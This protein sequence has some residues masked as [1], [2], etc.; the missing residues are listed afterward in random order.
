VA[1][2]SLGWVALVGPADSA[3]AAT[4]AEEYCYDSLGRLQVALLCGT[5]YRYHYDA[6]GNLIER[7]VAAGTAPLVCD[8]DRDGLPD[9]IETN[10]GDFGSASDTGTDPFLA[11]TDGDG[12]TDGVETNTGT[13]VSPSDTGSNPHD[14]DTDDDGVDDG[15]E[16]H[17]GSD[18]N[19][20][21]A[22]VPALSPL[23]SRLLMGL[24]LLTGAGIAWRTRRARG[25]G[26]LGL[27][28][29]SG[30]TLFATPA[31]AAVDCGPGAL[32]LGATE[33]VKHFQLRATAAEAALGN[34]TYTVSAASGSGCAVSPAF[35][36]TAQFADFSVDACAVP[37]L[38]SGT[39]V[40]AWS[41]PS[42][43]SGSCAVH[44]DIVTDSPPP[45]SANNRDA[46]R[47]G[48]VDLF[49]GERVV[50]PRTLL[51]LGGRL[52]VVFAVNYASAR[53]RDGQGAFG[54][55]DN[56]RHS[57]DFRLFSVGARSEIRIA[58]PSGRTLH[59]G[60]S[61]G[62][63]TLLGPLETPY[64]LVAD[65]AEHV[66]LH[67]WSHRRYRFNAAGQL[68]SI[69]D[70]NGNTLTL[71]YNSQLLSE[72]S[73]G[74]GRT[75]TFGYDA[76][77]FLAQVGDG[78][79]TVSFSVAAR[80]LVQWT[81]AA[82]NTTQFA[83]SNAV[84]DTPGLLTQV[85]DAGGSVAHTFGYSGS[86]R[87]VSRTAASLASGGTGGTVSFALVGSTAT[88]LDEASG[89]WTFTLDAE[90]NPLSLVDAGGHT[91]TWS[92]DAQGRRTS[93]VDAEGRS[94]SVA[95][96]ATHGA[97]SQLNRPDAST[98]TVAFASA[99]DA[100]GL[101]DVDATSWIDFDGTTGSFV[102]DAAGNVTS[103]TDAAGQ[104]W[105]LSYDAAGAPLSATS[106]TGVVATFAYNADGTLV[107][108]TDAAGNVTAWDYDPL[109]RPV[110]TQ[111]ADATGREQVFD[112]NDRLTD[113]TD[114]LGQT[115]QIGRDGLGRPVL[116]IDPALG[117]WET[118]Y[119]IMGAAVAT[120]DPLGAGW[121][122]G[123]DE[124]QLLATVDDPTSV[125]TQ[126]GYD[127]KGSPVL[128]TDNAGQTRSVTVDNV[129]V[130]RSFT[131]RL[132]DTWTFD[133]DLLDRPIRATSPLG[134]S[135]ERTVDL[136]GRTMSA[137]GPGGRTW[138]V[139][140]DA[141]GAVS[142]RTGP[143]GSQASI[144]RNTAGQATTFTD[145]NGASWTQ[146]FDAAG[147]LQSFSDPL[148]NATTQSYDTRNRMNQQSFPGGLGNLVVSYDGNGRLSQRAYSDGTTHSYSHDANGRLSGATGVTLTR[149]AVGRVT[150]SNGIGT[151]YDPAGRITQIEYGPGVWVQYGYDANGWLQSVTDWTDPVSP[152]V[153]IDRNLE[154]L[155]VSIARANGTSTT[156]TYD[157]DGRL[158]SLQHLGPGP[159]SL[160]EVTIA[161]GA[162][163]RPASKS[164]TAAVVELGS[165]V[166]TQTL[167]RNSAGWPTSFDGGAIA[168]NALGRRLS[169]LGHTFTPRL[170]GTLASMTVGA[171]AVAFDHDA[172]GVP[173]QIAAG[174]ESTALTWNYATPV[175]T[176]AAIDQGANVQLN[177]FDPQTGGL[178]YAVDPL[179]DQRTDVHFDE[180]G[181]AVLWTDAAG[182]LLLAQ[183]YSPDG[184]E[185][186]RV[187]DPAASGLVPIGFG[188]GD[189]WLELGALF[190]VP[191]G[192]VVDPKTASALRNIEWQAPYFH[193][194][195]RQ[196]ISNLDS[197]GAAASSE[198][199]PLTFNGEAWVDG[200]GVLSPSSSYG[201]T[202]TGVAQQ[203][204]EIGG[205]IVKLPK[206]VT[207]TDD[208]DVPNISYR[209]PWMGN[210]GRRPP[211]GLTKL[212]GN[213]VEVSIALPSRLHVM[214][215]NVDYGW[216]NC[217]YALPAWLHDTSRAPSGHIVP[218]L[219][220]R[221]A[222]FP[223][224]PEATPPCVSGTSRLFGSSCDAIA[225]P[226]GSNLSVKASAGTPTIRL[227]GSS[228]ASGWG[229]CGGGSDGGFLGDHDQGLLH[230]Q[231]KDW[232]SIRRTGKRFAR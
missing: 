55:G 228:S 9:T 153:A 56:W 73:D 111:Y 170:D 86:G 120:Q 143:D 188:A 80:K 226:A 131:N 110:Q 58:L 232:E 148:G 215:G 150:G 133:Y 195:N 169:G 94:W 197:V 104:T 158:T 66:L 109:R 37:S 208:I 212:L 1:V 97:I 61:G 223:A 122:L 179:T 128:S 103:L 126:I 210:S 70:R 130:P 33:T 136:L 81:D 10:T 191:G 206:S 106:P 72:V 141:R 45:S 32:T 213:A 157:D 2:L 83:Y 38:G 39:V 34:T 29:S 140:R 192:G 189:G 8:A 71:T 205:F 159:V 13:F 193:N 163:G 201:R 225:S 49:T 125:T 184:Q 88:V 134:V 91:R 121:T 77:N 90:G 194:G 115:I 51:D 156:R 42:G 36:S 16:V 154:G 22:S 17:A 218:I 113:V 231:E 211:F 118:S 18:P 142:T 98:A 203:R 220:A 127:A 202:S 114:A 30:L 93:F 151:T 21:E 187:G 186:A 139:E 26:A 216:S 7:V 78:T 67:P 166:G 59:F 53:V 24:L 4:C 43:S 214:F 167:V 28:V 23:G 95:Y 19:V 152:A 135:Q 35:Q 116:V 76:N 174:A 147:R 52:P 185:A 48:G 6:A 222:D 155:I 161:Y 162:D 196:A 99:A 102:R 180:M 92:Y 119:N 138:S 227:L 219:P 85:T 108:A 31:R 149:D 46:P 217:L 25:L 12:L 50:A 146:S 57:Y 207:V 173:T 209:L 137:T 82:G 65:G 129:G 15:A 117:N 175:P 176:L 3:R 27:L 183:A 44:Y 112:A 63:Y 199:V 229:G 74:L 224:T 96:E 204:S 200:G 101:T 54:L 100:L 164:R 145:P 79:R 89:V 69:F 165:A 14:L 64:Q 75:L 221:T 181:N 198:S 124:R 87:A 47:W 84:P 230:L 178:L 11:D 123:Y 5:E 40:V 177:I 62:S 182:N 171:E 107:S 68:V 160:F 168:H 105:S 132:G 190:L 144:A 60:E 20:A 172:F 41:A